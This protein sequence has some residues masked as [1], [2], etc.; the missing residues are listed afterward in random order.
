[1]CVVFPPGL[2]LHGW[3]SVSCGGTQVVLRCWLG[4]WDKAG[5]LGGQDRTRTCVSLFK[6]RASRAWLDD[7]E[8]WSWQA[9]LGCGAAAQTR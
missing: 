6:Q 2:C 1:M 5:C 7:E 3:G 9:L 4:Q 8:L